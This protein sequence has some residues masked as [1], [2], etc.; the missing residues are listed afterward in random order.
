MPGATFVGSGDFGGD[1]Y[2]AGGVGRGLGLYGVG[3]M[4]VQC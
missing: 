4:A 1:C 3:F 2:V